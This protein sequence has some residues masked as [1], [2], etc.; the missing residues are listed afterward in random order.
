MN[1]EYRMNNYHGII[2]LIQIALHREPKIE[3]RFISSMHKALNRNCCL[4]HCEE[5]EC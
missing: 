2:I 1:I 5:F 3:A 4:E